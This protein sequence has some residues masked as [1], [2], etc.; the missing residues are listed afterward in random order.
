EITVRRGP[1]TP[2]APPALRVLKRGE[3]DAA[4]L[5][6]RSGGKRFAVGGAN[7]V[8][9]LQPVTG[10]AGFC[11]EPEAGH[12][13]PTRFDAVEPSAP[14]DFLRFAFT[15]NRPPIFARRSRTGCPRPCGRRSPTDCRQ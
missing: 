12:R 5:A 9:P 2:P 15:K 7:G 3:P 11:T 10:C 6:H 13:S 4:E 1:G 14:D 8:E